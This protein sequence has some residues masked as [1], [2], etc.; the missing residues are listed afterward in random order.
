MSLNNPISRCLIVL[1]LFSVASGCAMGKF[2]FQGNVPFDTL[3]GYKTVAVKVT[4]DAGPKCTQDVPENLKGAAIKQFQTQYPTVFQTVR[5][6]PTGEAEEL[7]VDIHIT[8]YR[9]G[10]RFW[11]SMLIG[12][13]QSKVLTDVNLMDST[14]NNQ[15]ATGKLK[16][17]YALGGI[18]GASIGVED[19]VNWSGQ[20]TADAVAESKQGT[21]K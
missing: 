3:K 5:P 4:N 19:L 8:K 9:K 15:L 7:L 21:K 10:S 20:R 18:M 6:A 14:T 13:G 1:V 11:R 16:L 2:Q 12:L 17:V